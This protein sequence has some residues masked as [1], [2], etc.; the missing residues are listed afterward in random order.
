VLAAEV[1]K[2]IEDEIG[3]DWTQSNSHGVD[4]RRCL[5]RE[6]VLRTYTNSFFDPAKP[7]DKTNRRNIKLW[8][9]LEEAPYR[10]KSYQIV[11]DDR[12]DLFG[13]A[14]DRSFIGLYGNFI[15]T[16]GACEGQRCGA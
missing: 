10:K 15:N 13:L 7:K 3:E 11:Y 12:K 5:L 14:C 8:L 9:V 4:V 16:L 6:P 1:R 2:R